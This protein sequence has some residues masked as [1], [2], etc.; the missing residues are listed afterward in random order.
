MQNQTKALNP[1][2]RLFIGN[3]WV[4]ADNLETYPIINPAT[5]EI[6]GRAAK[7]GQ[8][9]LVEAVEHAVKGFEN[10]RHV[11][12]YD[13]SKILRSAAE[14]LRKRGSAIARLITLEQGKPVAEA[15]AEVNVAADTIEW[16]AEE[17]RRTYGRVVPSRAYGTQQMVV[18]E[19]I[20]PVAVF[21]PWNFPLN[22]AARKIA[23]ALAAGCSVVAKP[24]EEAPSCVAELARVFADAGLP[25]GVLNLVF[26]V[27][28]E[29]SD[30]LIPHPAIRKIS[31]TGSTIVGKKLT[32]LA[33]QHMKRA[34]MELGGH[35]PTLVF[36]DVDVEA[37]ATTL[38][39][40][41]FRNAGQVCI[42]PTRF[43]VHQSIYAEFVDRF[44]TVASTLKI[45]DGM[46]PGTEM[47]PLANERRLLA[48]EA[49]VQDAIDHGA[50]LRAGGRRHG[51]VGY[52]YEPTV[53]SD[54]PHTV[55]AMNE[56]PFG[57]LALIRPFET[58]AEALAEANRLPYGLAAFAFTRSSETVS[59]VSA[60]IQAG[61]ISFNGNL[62]ALPE[63]PFGG[64]KDSG[65]GSEGG[66][67]A[68]E[69]YMNTKL[70]NLNPA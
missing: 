20:G 70:I 23:A 31:F 60:E 8:V 54:V 48:T 52:Y 58:A 59:R 56:E 49:L 68:M 41:K 40:A 64:I 22:Q 35:A 36:E 43:L 50:V 30:F 53:L 11:A 32:A 21:T 6:I 47:G 65:Y 7:A 14:L 26:G 17:G 61:M 69:A 33:G 3:E 9:D 27:P 66:S 38:A 4:D 12:P 44:S 13:R 1:D 10:W 67:E 37:A 55:R 28:S 25:A 34:T 46:A 2:V 24:A 39:R 62:L 63:V 15:A 16:F 18:K 51:N 19:P 45:G 29:I 42:S 57:P 5:G